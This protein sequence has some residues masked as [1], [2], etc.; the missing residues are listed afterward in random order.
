MVDDG[1]ALLLFSGPILAS[2]AVGTGWRTLGA[3][4]TVTSSGS[5]VVHTID[6]RPAIEFLARYLDVTGPA[7]FGN[8]LSVIEAGRDEPYYRAITATDP[9]SGSVSVAGEIPVGSMVGLS[10]A[11][12]D[13]VLAG[14]RGALERATEAFPA[15]AKPKGR[16]RLLVR[17]A[18]LPARL[19]DA[20]RGRA[21]ARWLRRR[22]LPMACIY[23][24]GEI[25]PVRGIETSRY[26]NETFVT[27][28]LGT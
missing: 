20:S 6:D 27:L 28:L 1:V 5:G 3:T 21:G 9:A 13:E 14:T 2:T 4:G 22:A 16:A 10:T 24:F 26:F 23:C 25:G 12:M 7:S 18:P 17:G 19:E 11:E 8:P 15:G